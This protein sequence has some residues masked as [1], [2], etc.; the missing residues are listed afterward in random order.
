MVAVA[1]EPSTRERLIDAAIE[2][3][4]AQGYEG[5]RLQ[6]V[7]RAAGLT[8]GAVYSNFRDKAEL[9][10]EAIGTRSAAEI[11]DLAARGPGRRRCPPR[12]ATSAVASSSATPGPCC[13]TPSSR[14]AATPISPSTC[15]SVPRA[16]RRGS[17]GVAREAQ[18]EDAIDAAVDPDAL[19]A[20]L[21]DDRARQRS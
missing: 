3:F 20:P 21:H 12:C 10:F 18:S 9:L 5:T 2:V 11:D 13:S 6:D 8:T 19:G 7:A 4:A 15:A 14:R 16:A 1:V 17:A